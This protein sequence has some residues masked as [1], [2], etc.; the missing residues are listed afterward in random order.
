MI[1]EENNVTLPEWFT[2]EIRER[3]TDLDL[4]SHRWDN[5]KGTKFIYHLCF[6]VIVHQ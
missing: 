1:Q 4:I 3:L 6:I 2:S 5:G